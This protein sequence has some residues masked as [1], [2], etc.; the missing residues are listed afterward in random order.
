M[1]SARM[2]PGK[3]KKTSEKIIHSS[4]NLSGTNLVKTPGGKP[5]SSFPELYHSHFPFAEALLP[6]SGLSRLVF[7]VSMSLSLS[8]SHTHTHARARARAR[9]RTPLN[10]RSAIR[11]GRF[12]T[13]HSKHNRRKSMPS[14]GNRNRNPRHQTAAELRLLD[15]THAHRNRPHSHYYRTALHARLF[16]YR[17][18]KTSS[19]WYLEY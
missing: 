12:C 2:K 16:P 9:G 11:R 15:R 8:L 10:M 1:R 19:D 4:A 17:R 13:T 18:L 7:E 3:K 6:K 5:V 14:S